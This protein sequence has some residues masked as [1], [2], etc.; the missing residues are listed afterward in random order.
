M[1]LGSVSSDTAAPTVTRARDKRDV[2]RSSIREAKQAL[3]N[4]QPLA[5]E[6]TF[7]TV[8]TRYIE[9]QRKQCSGGHLSEQELRRQNDIVEKNLLPFFGSTKLAAFARPR[10]M[11][12]SR[13]NR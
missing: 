11:R 13:Q 1:S 8:S 7:A 10:S 6:D 4:G 3:A 12:T 2:L 9:Y 5:T